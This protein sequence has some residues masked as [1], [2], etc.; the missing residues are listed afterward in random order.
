MISFERRHTWNAVAAMRSFVARLKRHT[1]LSTD[2]FDHL[3]AALRLEVATVVSGVDVVRQGD[4]PRRSVFVLSGTL[5]RYQTL[6]TGARQYISLHMAGDMPDLQCF[7][8]GELDHSLEAVEESM[9]ALAPH[10]QLKAVL[11]KSPAFA[12]ALWRESLLDA[13]VVRQAVTTNGARSSLERIAHLFCEH[14]VRNW[15]AGLTRDR[16]CDFP[17]NQSQVGQMLGLSIVTVNRLVRRLRHEGCAEVRG[18]R[19]LIRDWRKLRARAA[20]DPC[21]LQLDLTAGALSPPRRK[22]PLPA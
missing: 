6:A 3:L 9:V 14:Y 16:T 10:E 11:L 7:M 19:L 8:L 5:A 21:Y 4:R 12:A 22:P 2:D 17:L 20:F 1:S 18:R 13:A 15:Q